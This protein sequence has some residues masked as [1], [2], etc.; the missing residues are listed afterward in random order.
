LALRPK[1]SLLTTTFVLFSECLAQAQ[2]TPA[3]PGSGPLEPFSGSEIRPLI[4]RFTADR[5]NLERF[6][7]HEFSA[8]RRSRLRS[9]YGDVLASLDRFDFP[10]LS[11]DGRVDHLL[12]SNHARYKLR[13]LELEAQDYAEIEPL[14]PFLNGLAELEQGRRR[15]VPVDSA[16]AAST[17]NGFRKQIDG[18]RQAVV[19]GKLT[20]PSKTA[21]YRAAGVTQTL[22][23]AL[24]NWF[25]GY[26][27][28]DPSFTWWMADPWKGLDGALDGY[29]KTVREKLVGLKADD[30][31]AIVGRPAGR[32]LLMEQ[33]KAEMVAYTPEELVEIA[34]REFAWCDR[35]MLRASRDLG[36]GEDWKKALE[37]VKN[38][39]VEPGSQPRIIREL[40]QEAIDF[41]EK[42]DLV[43]VP[44]LAKETWRMDMMSAEAQMV[45]PFFLG[46]ER[47]LVSFP[48]AGMP[49]EAKLMSLR[50]NNVHFSRATVH[51][52][53]IPGHHLQGFMTA[54]HKPY[55]GIFRTPF[56]TEGWAL[57]WEMVLWDMQFPAKAEDRIGFLFWRMHRCA[58][59]IFSLN[60]HLGTWTPQQCIDFLIERVGHEPDNASA[61]V[62]RS[63][64]GTTY[65][66]LYQAGYMLGAL[67]FRA[68][69]KELVA[70]GKMPVKRFHD[71]ILMEN[72]MPVEMVRAILMKQNLTKD[73]QPSWRFYPLN[74]SSNSN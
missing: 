29:I 46:G 31:Y 16:K 61:E 17:V 72:R 57:Y 21:A 43:T 36:F 41:V 70:S 64:E 52:E 18:L 44:E 63:F 50:G 6:Y 25:D 22:R 69:A 71:Q 20:A 11:L 35:E 48:T 68:L 38:L 62:R 14:I 33:L 58:R 40:A 32:T 24:K 55:R 3:I 12:L 60:F 34:N 28:Y 56:W 74:G 37:H 65:P 66:P 5:G 4:E 27:S 39:H 2:G 15:L 54:R 59:I 45:N 13:E 30:K 47:I 10:K 73:F 1:Q 7:P 8:A 9:F 23:T 53:L 26:N 19:S 42:R 51:H 49:H 67:Q